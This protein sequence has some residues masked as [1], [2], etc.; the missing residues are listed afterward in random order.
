MQGHCGSQKHLVL[1]DKA[2]HSRSGQLRLGS[3][4]QRNGAETVQSRTDRR[5]R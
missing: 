5:A 4:I 2:L 3:R 1:L